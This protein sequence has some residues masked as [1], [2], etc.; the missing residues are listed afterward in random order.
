MKTKV[1]ILHTSVGYGIKVTAENIYEKV[2]AIGEYDVKIEDYGNVD[3]SRFA[4]GVVNIYLRI[5]EKFPWFWGW[6]YSSK[7]V[8]FV[9]LPMRKF[10]ASFKAKKILALLREY[11]P[12]IVISTEFVTTGIPAYLKSKGLYRGKLVAVFS[13]YHLHPF[14]LFDEVDQYWCNIPE[15]VAEMKAMGIDGSKIVLTGSVVPQ[16]FL[17]QISREQACL[18]TEVLTSMPMVLVTSG[19]QARLRIKDTLLKLLKSPVSFQ[20]VVVCGRNEEM[21]KELSKI[22]GPSNHPLKVLGYVINMDVLMSAASVL[23]GKTGGP[24]IIEAM[25]KDLPVVITDVSPGHELINLEYLKQKGL[26]EYGR[27]PREVV[28][29]VEEILQ[30]RN[31][32]NWHQAFQNTLYPV[33]ALTIDQALAKIR[34]EQPNLKV[35]NYQE[36]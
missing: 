36:F 29:L 8:M 19:A 15:Q 30:K 10:T 16:K 2:L 25:V 18:E 31:R 11:Q 5:L 22:T 17:K 21:K 7:L 14:W 33:N 4:K 24:T 9:T 26:V 12:A 23:V 20:V 3:Q 28:F 35:K 13:D 27:I 6:L 34:P 1:L 32:R